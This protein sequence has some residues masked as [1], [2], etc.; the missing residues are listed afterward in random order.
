MSTIAVNDSCE[1]CVVATTHRFLKVTVNN[2][3]ELCAVVTTHRFL[4]SIRKLVFLKISQRSPLNCQ[5]L[6]KI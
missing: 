5:T 2:S 3:C 1:L 4:K 6:N